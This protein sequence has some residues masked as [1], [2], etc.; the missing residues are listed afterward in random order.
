M[1]K[2]EIAN[3]EQFL[4]FPFLYFQMTFFADVKT[5]ACLGKA[6]RV[7]PLPH[8]APIRRTNDI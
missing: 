3:Y 5:R 2:G 7:N 1:G 8:D 6:L 4:L